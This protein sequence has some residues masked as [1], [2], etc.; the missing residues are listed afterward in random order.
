MTNQ[1]TRARRWLPWIGALGVSLLA[2]C[3]PQIVTLTIHF[4]STDT[5]LVSR[6]LR[7]RVYPASSTSCASLVST[8][9]NN[10]SPEVAPIFTRD[11]ITPCEARDG[12][13]LPDPGE[14]LLSILVEGLDR[15]GNQTILAGCIEGEVY[16][17]ARITVD[18]Y[19]TGRYAA[20]L[21]A[22]PPGSTTPDQR[23]GG[24][25]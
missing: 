16:T 20:A 23:C 10:R 11:G 9:V 25:Q 3:G 21:S 6:F 15:T 14:G 13:T 8:V 5:F 17:D 18:L 1:E 19:P 22:D 12:L 4:P 7:I 24:G 2:A